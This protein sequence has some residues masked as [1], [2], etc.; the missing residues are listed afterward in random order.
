MKNKKKNVNPGL[1][2]LTRGFAKEKELEAN[3][4]YEIAK[5]LENKKKQPGK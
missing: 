5:E 1:Q 3:L 4:K 2:N